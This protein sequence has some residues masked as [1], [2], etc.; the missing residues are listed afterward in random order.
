MNQQERYE[1][2]KMDAYRFKW[3]YGNRLVFPTTQKDRQLAQAYEKLQDAVASAFWTNE[4]E[5][6][7]F[8]G[9]D[10]VF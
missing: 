2:A 6:A 5:E 4:M 7:I 10:A 9:S 8:R 3:E 1:S